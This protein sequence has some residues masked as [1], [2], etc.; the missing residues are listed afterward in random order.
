MNKKF[1]V[2][3]YNSKKWNYHLEKYLKSFDRCKEIHYLMSL[4]IFEEKYFFEE[5]YYCKEQYI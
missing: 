5:Y 3:I 2:T 4:M 1:D